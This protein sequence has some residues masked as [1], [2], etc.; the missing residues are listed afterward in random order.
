MKKNKS[1]SKNINLALVGTV[2]L[3]SVKEDFKKVFNIKLENYGLSE[4]T[5]ISMSLKI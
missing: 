3:T 1:F 2:L 5:F 4:T